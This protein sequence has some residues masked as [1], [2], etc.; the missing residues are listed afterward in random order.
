MGGD[1]N[2]CILHLRGNDIDQSID[3]GKVIKSVMERVDTLREWGIHVVIGEILPRAEFALRKREVP[4][5]L[6]EIHRKGL[7]KRFRRAMKEILLM[8]PVCL[9][10]RGGGLHFN[11]DEDE[12]HLSESGMWSYHGTL[13]AEFNQYYW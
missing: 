11:Y 7:N 1:D 9:M 8:F 2:I 13:Q 10:Y 3:L 5:D 12:V 4:L 6:F